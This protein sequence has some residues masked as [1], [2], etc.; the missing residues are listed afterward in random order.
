MK[1]TDMVVEMD[2]DE[3][4][5]KVKVQY[6]ERDSAERLGR[7]VE[8]VVYVDRRGLSLRQLNTAALI[9]AREL[10]REMLAD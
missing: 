1:H 10:L 3:K 5:T 6:L 9:Q 8:V 4:N 2:E 7:F